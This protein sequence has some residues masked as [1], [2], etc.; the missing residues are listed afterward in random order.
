MNGNIELMNI[1]IVLII[2]VS[3]FDSNFFAFDPE[4][5]GDRPVD[6]C[7]F[8]LFGVNVVLIWGKIW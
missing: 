4:Q 6:A 8:A 1:G 2:A 5:I 3:P 7:N